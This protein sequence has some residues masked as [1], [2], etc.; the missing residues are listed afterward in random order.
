MKDIN[1]NIITKG[2]VMKLINDAGNFAMQ[3]RRESWLNIIKV[4]LGL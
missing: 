3:L 4:K 2:E 1:G